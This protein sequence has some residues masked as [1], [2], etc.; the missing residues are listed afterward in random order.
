MNIETDKSLQSLC[1]M[2]IPA[3]ARAYC[4]PTRLSELEQAIEQARRNQWPLLILGGGSNLL[5]QADFPG[6]VIR[7]AFDGIELNEVAPGQWQ[8][9]AGAGVNWQTLVDF[10]LDQGLWGLE[11]LTRIPGTV[12]AAPIQNIGAYG[13]ELESRFVSLQAWDLAHNCL[14]EFDRQACGFSYRDSYFKQ[15][16]KGRF[17]IL[18]VTLALTRAARPVLSYQG[19]TD[20]VPAELSGPAQVAERVSALRAAKLPDPGVIPNCGSF[21][22]NPVVDQAQARVLLAEYPD[23]VSYPQA[24][25]RIKL[26]AGWLIDRAGLKGLTDNGVG[27]HQ[28]QAL[29]LVNPGRR[30]GA[31]VL[32][33]A[34]KI[35]DAVQAR[36]GVELTIEPQI[37]P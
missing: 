34:R 11:N 2:A 17:I 6:L 4:A 22:H 5:L 36:F 9:R 23:L 27:V 3:S 10:T 21:F 37:Y 8:V 16:G 28:Q 26:A 7:P 18:Q 19:L 33:F 31:E 12:G 1:T 35:T 14:R 13:V 30:S 32:A 29:V 15:Q 20:L 25:G 24:D